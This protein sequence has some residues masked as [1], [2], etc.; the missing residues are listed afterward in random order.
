L[1]KP[2]A[3]AKELLNQNFETSSFFEILP[4]VLLGINGVGFQI[5]PKL[6]HRNPL[7]HVQFPQRHPQNQAF[8]V[9]WTLVGSL[10]GA[11]ENET[12]LNAQYI[13]PSQ[14]GIFL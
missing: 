14:R 9:P 13:Q 8:S 12:R 11:H 10:K 3:P 4:V 2:S 6:N 5:R 7:S 1:L